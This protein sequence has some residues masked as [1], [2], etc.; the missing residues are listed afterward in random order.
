MTI[1]TSNYRSDTARLFVE[2][3]A[4]NDYYLF[5]SSMSN[6]AVENT[7]VSKRSFLEKTIFGKKLPVNNV[8]YI[9]ENNTWQA[10]TVY[11]QYDDAA[12]LA[13]EDY[14]VT[15]YP[16]DNATGDYKIYKCLFNNYGGASINPPNYQSST[17]DQTYIMPDGYTWKYMYSLS[18]LEF[19]KYNTRGY[20]PII[21]VSTN[22]A[23]SSVSSANSAVITSKSSINQIFI[24]N[25]N[26]NGGYESVI[27][28]IFQVLRGSVNAIT[29]TPNTA[30]ALNAIG[31]YYS[32]YTLYVTN[33]N[34]RSQTY[35]VDTYTYDPVTGRATIT[36]VEGTPTDGVLIDTATF[37]LLPRIKIQGDGTGAVGIPSVATNGSI[38]SVTIL[39]AGSG[40]TNATAKVIDPFAFDPNLAGSLD[41]RVT[42][43]PILSPAGGHGKNLVEELSCTRVLAYTNLDTVDN[44]SIPI[45]NTYASI[46]IVKNPEF[47]DY[48]YPTVFDN[49]IELAVDTNPFT[50]NETITQIETVNTASDFFDDVRFSAKVHEVT[51][52]FIYLAEYSGPYP[53][54]QGSN[55]N[56][57]FSDISLDITLPLTTSQG[58]RIQI[59]TDNNPV[60]TGGYDSAYPGF[61][62]SPYVQRTGEVYYMHRFLPIT[63]TASSNEQYKIILEF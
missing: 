61:K 4:A 54:D 27:G 26:Q 21:D 23:N 22:Y 8:F 47:K 40:Y 15:V 39:N 32:G 60:Y 17:P 63:R 30:N 38:S 53:D 49:R 50:V 3:V 44:T 55:A 18:V 34:T 43:R 48:S 41:V 35:Q 56:T 24:E 33:Q 51:G 57:D 5:T 46:G 7:A 42:L 58:Q 45:T 6:T 19:D 29:I 62:L 16:A 37:N 2:D 13:D 28:T 14:Y 10:G 59:N 31:N 36:L 11:T 20:I 1:I 25:L 12:D 9:I 52:D